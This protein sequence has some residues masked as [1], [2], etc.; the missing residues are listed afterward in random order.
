MMHKALI[1]RYTN[2]VKRWCKGDFVEIND[3]WSERRIPSCSQP[4]RP[5]TITFAIIFAKYTI[6]PLHTYSSYSKHT[7][8]SYANDISQLIP[9]HLHNIIVSHVF[10]GPTE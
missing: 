2:N 10:R 8:Q 4:G 5:I 6:E 1:I 7:V 3:V 9:S